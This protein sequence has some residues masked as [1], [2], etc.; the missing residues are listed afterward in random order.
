LVPGLNYL[1]AEVKY[2]V[3]AEG[4]RSLED[5]LERRLRISIESA[6]HGT[7]IATEAARIVAPIVGWSDSEVAAEITAYSKKISQEMVAL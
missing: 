4:A 7:D 1:K 6:A 5:I 3:T 2:A